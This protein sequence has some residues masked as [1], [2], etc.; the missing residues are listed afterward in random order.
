MSTKRN[1]VIVGAGF[2]GTSIAASLSVKLDAAKYNLI[3]LNSRP[4]AIPLPAA[5][6]LVVSPSSKLE[7]SVFVPLDKL[8]KNGTGEI[9]VGIVKTIEEKK[10]GKGGT[11]VLESGERVPYEIL[12]I[13]SGSKWNGPLDLPEHERDVLPHVNAWREKFAKAT[14]VVLA[15]GGAVGIGEFTLP[16]INTF[17]RAQECLPLE[18][19]GELKDEYPVSSD[20][21]HSVYSHLPA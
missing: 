6:R 12:V 17:G 3:L 10:G 2:A 13:A 20:C 1:I 4:Y 19:A 5:A 15:G 21:L 7:D 16:E 11:V 9:K 14:H 18:L 8:Y